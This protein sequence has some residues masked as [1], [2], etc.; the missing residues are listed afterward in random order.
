M[1]QALEILKLEGYE[2]YGGRVPQATNK[3]KYTTLKVLCPPGTEH[4]EIFKYENIN[5]L[6]D[7]ISRDGG[8]TFEPSF[9]YPKSMDSNRVQIRYSEEGGKDKDG[10][11][12][13]RRGV[14]DLSLGNSNYSQVRIL[15]DDTHYIK[16]MAGIFG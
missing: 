4:K 13:L 16:G 2:V 1:N 15:V 9:V 11:V 6:D 3:G 7:Y 5:S 10:V 14:D 12:E 8:D